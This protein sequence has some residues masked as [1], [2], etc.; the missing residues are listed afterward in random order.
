MAAK[1]IE[2]EDLLATTSAPIGA[3]ARN[4]SPNLVSVQIP[5][6]RLPM[7]VSTTG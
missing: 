5:T 6:A 7:S 3:K 2:L 4:V 1:E